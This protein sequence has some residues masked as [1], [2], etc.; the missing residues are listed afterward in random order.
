MKPIFEKKDNFGI[1]AKKIKSFRGFPPMFHP[2]AELIY[3]I[4]GKIDMIIDG[5]EHTLSAGEMSI[6]FPYVVHSYEN[7]PDAEIF[8]V[9]FE[10]ET[11]S[12]FEKEL[13]ESKESISADIAWG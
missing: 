4:S 9:L 3:V 11:A 13:A 5:Y 12:L 10:L 6:V 1:T 2:H 8:M 7:A